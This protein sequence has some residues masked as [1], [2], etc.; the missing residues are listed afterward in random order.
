VNRTFVLLSVATALAALT[1]ACGGDDTSKLSS[2]DSTDDG[3]G[4]I[5]GTKDESE[6]APAKSTTPT[7]TTPAKAPATT[8]PAKTTTNAGTCDPAKATTKADCAKCCATQ[9]APVKAV[10]D[11]A[12]GAA[13][14]CKDACGDN[15]CAGG[16]PNVGCGICLITAQCD[17]GDFGG[18]DPAEA[19]ACIQQC[20][21]KP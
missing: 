2:A 16:A 8:T 14:K 6:P 12:C 18:G 15:V 21:D 1:F 11:C 9:A 4:D 13:S 19:T 7:S 10:S 20:A 17:L 3:K 5:V